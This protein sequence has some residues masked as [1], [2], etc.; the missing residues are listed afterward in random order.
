MSQ[1]FTY[2][3]GQMVPGTGLKVIRPLGSG[4]MGAVYEVEETSVEAP[5]M[6]K[7]VHA[8]LLRPGSNVAERMRQEAKTEARVN[9]ND[10]V[11]VYRAGVTA[12]SPPL[13]F[14]VMDRLSGYTVRQ[15][16]RWHRSKGGRVPL[17]WVLWIASS[18]L[19]A[20]DH[21]HKNGI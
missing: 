1:Q 9:H 3:P 14:Y 10:I 4:G 7:V 17:N 18:L 11:R 15:V 6:M 16:L 21:A 12:E 19:Q 2:R 8:H 13:P 20:L 5:F